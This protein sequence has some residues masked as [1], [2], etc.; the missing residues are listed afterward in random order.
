MQKLAE[1]LDL[2][3]SRLFV[4]R[5]SELALVQAWL[6][7]AQAPTE[8]LFL[9]GMGGIGKSAL[10]LQF[11]NMA[12]QEEAAAVWLDGRACTDSPAGFMEALHG[13]FTSHPQAPHELG[14][15]Y[16]QLANLIASKKTVLCI[17]HYDS[18][19]RI[20]SWLRE[21]FLP[22][23]PATGLLVILAARRDL[24]AAWSSDLAWRSRSRSIQLGTLSREEIINYLSHRG[25]QNTNEME[26]LCSHTRGLPLAMTLYAERMPHSPLE[27]G[28]SDWPISMRI[29]AEVLG[30]EAAAEF[31][32]LSEILCIVPYA[33]IE[34]LGKFLSAPL[35]LQELA[36]INRLSYIRPTV[37]GITLHDTARF[38]LADDFRTREP[39][40]YR[41]LWRRIIDE[42][43]LELSHAASQEKGR[44]VSLMLSA[45][46]DMYQIDSIP[47]LSP[48]LDV[49]YM[50]PFQPSDLP[51]LHQMMKEE[52]QYSISSEIDHA[53]MDVLASYFP[54]SIRVYRGSDEKPL[55]FTA[56]LHLY[57]ETVALLERLFPGL[58]DAVFPKEIRLLRRTSMEEADTYYHL[59]A[60][61]SSH[62]PD[63]SY[64]ELIGVITKDL[65]T[66]HSIGMRFILVTAYRETNELLGNAGFRSRDLPAHIRDHLFQGAKA[67]LHEQDW[68]GTNFVDQ[69]FDLIHFT[70]DG[71]ETRSNQFEL[72]EKDVKTAIALMNDHEALAQ[73]E[74][75]AKLSCSG[76]TLQQKLHSVFS[77]S[78]PF[79]LNSNN[80]ALL[81][82]Y[83]K[84]PQLGVEMAAQ[85]L[86]MSR[87]TY[88]RIR[89]ETL[90]NL[91]DVLIRKTN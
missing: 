9:S 64:H 29:S 42:L 87:A 69:I 91:R 40:R 2:E 75:A 3:R 23:L 34:W 79:P 12:R 81:K 11:M 20:E 15:I 1:L 5:K 32:D 66:H 54:D 48:K 62:S 6:G 35:T 55:A 63:Y 76:F 8:V 7:N 50:E 89:K 70:P 16:Q 60:S 26:R 44:I 21:V 25:W 78:P 65:I 22:N 43:A 33:T 88:Y 82:L 31:N 80:L 72:T 17:D 83:A 36:R 59:R 58:L 67:S 13:Y 56:G 27:S 53:I 51:H 30:E 74:L 38:F 14:N 84:A 71:N 49:L 61:A 10:L 28:Q 41:T 18:I 47:L 77:D 68:R 39:E 19:Q 45:S 4:G 37:G 57:K 73:S 46:Q 24:S 52:N 86:H 90:L 85:Q